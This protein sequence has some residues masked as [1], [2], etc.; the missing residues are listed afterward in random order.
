MGGGVLASLVVTLL[1]LFGIL[2]FLQPDALASRNMHIKLSCITSQ[3]PG[4]YRSTEIIITSTP[5]PPLLNNQQTS[6]HQPVPPTPPARK[7][8]SNKDTAPATPS[9]TAP[10]HLYSKDESHGAGG[11]SSGNAAARCSASMS[12]SRN[13]WMRSDCP[14]WGYSSRTGQI[15]PPWPTSRGSVNK[16]PRQSKHATRAQV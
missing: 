14:Y 1:L 6:F 9:S 2:P 10:P 5:P 16:Q 12:P 15:T 13:A 11:P 3:A 7:T 4:N 8:S